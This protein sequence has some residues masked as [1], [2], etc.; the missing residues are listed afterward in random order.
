MLAQIGI[1]NVALRQ[2]ARTIAAL[3]R[4]PRSRLT[5]SRGTHVNP[6]CVQMTSAS[7]A[8]KP[9]SQTV[10]QAA[11]SASV[12]SASGRRSSTRPSHGPAPPTRRSGI[13]GN[14]A[15]TRTLTRRETRHWPQQ[16]TRVL[17]LV[18]EQI[19][20]ESFDVDSCVKS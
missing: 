4:K 5:G 19:D 7:S 13:R 15:E 18:F 3:L 8:L 10:P 2:T 6:S 11:A 16:I 17:T 20:V 12:T 14:A 1:R 9:S